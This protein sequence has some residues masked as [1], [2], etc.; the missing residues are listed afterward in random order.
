MQVRFYSDAAGQT[1]IAA[2][3]G[4][5]DLV[6]TMQ[7][8]V[9]ADDGYRERGLESDL[10]GGTLAGCVGGTYYEVLLA[11]GAQ[12]ITVTASGGSDPGGAVTYRIIVDGEKG[13]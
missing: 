6:V 4:A 8:D 7:S 11:D 12:N 2:G 3:T 13:V 10:D 1:A 5:R 9:Y